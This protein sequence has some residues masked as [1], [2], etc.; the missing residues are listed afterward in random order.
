MRWRVAIL[1][2]A[3]PFA[4][5]EAVNNLLGAKV[6]V[7]IDGHPDAVMG[8]VVEAWME[9]IPNREIWVEVAVSGMALH[10]KKDRD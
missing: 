1:P 2:K 4:A 10:L 7:T 3:S 5:S 9:G 6:A 8:R